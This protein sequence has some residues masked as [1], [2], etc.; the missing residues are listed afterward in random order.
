MI[1]VRPLLV[2]LRLPHGLPRQQFPARALFLPNLQ[3]QQFDATG[4]TPVLDVASQFVAYD[5]RFA[6]HFDGLFGQVHRDEVRLSGG[7]GG[8]EHGL[9]FNFAR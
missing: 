4:F 1:L 3:H 9:V 6:G 8:K 5:G 7:N 2:F